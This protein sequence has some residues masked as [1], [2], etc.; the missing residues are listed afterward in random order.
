MLIVAGHVM[1]DPKV[2]DDYLAA[3][4]VVVESARR[5]DTCQDFAVSADLVDPG[6]V[7]VFERWD[8]REAVEEFRRSGPPFDWADAIR[9][10]EVAE[11]DVTGVRPLFGQ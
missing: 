11:Y 9:S 10:A 2:R 8:T 4:R 7:N 1:V 3:S 5:T 6:R